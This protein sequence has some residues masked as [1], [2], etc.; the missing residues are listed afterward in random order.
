MHRALD[1]APGD[2][3]WKRFS[4]K[5]KRPAFTV[6]WE[7]PNEFSKVISW[8]GSFTNLAAGGDQRSGGHNYES[9]TFVGGLCK[10]CMPSRMRGG[11][12]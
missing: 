5:W 3:C 1:L 7:R 10:R 6:A 9:V 8:T 11:T 2:Y 4:P 12:A